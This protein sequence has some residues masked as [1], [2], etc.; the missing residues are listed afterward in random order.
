MTF[1]NGVG[2]AWAWSWVRRLLTALSGLFFCE[3]G[4]RE[5]DVGYGR[6][7]PSRSVC[8]RKFLQA[9]LRDASETT[10]TPRVIACCALAFSF[11][12]MVRAFGW[13][14]YGK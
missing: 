12:V 8:D 4:W 10:T 2:P 7:F 14:S 11:W 3:A 13:A 6:G 1:E 5:H 9:M